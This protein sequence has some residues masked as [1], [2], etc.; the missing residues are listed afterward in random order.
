[1]IEQR[2]TGQRQQYQDQHF[3]QG[4]T[5]D[6]VIFHVT[7]KVHNRKQKGGRIN[8]FDPATGQY[9]A[10]SVS[11]HAEGF[12]DNNIEPGIAPV[13]LALLSRGY[14]TY[15]SCAGHCLSDRRF[16]GIAFPNPIVKMR[17][18]AQ[19]KHWEKEGVVFKELSS[20]IN[21]RSEV[22][23]TGMTSS[24]YGES[25]EQYVSTEEETKVFNIQFHARSSGYSFVEMIILEGSD[26]CSWTSEPVRAV[27]L[28]FRK[29]LHW[30]RITA[31]V[32]RDCSRLVL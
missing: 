10:N 3:L 9:S 22:S 21:Q 18:M 16:V 15:S 32:A 26:T 6:E 30:D 24:Y 2:V 28:W 29:W 7:H 5:E 11:P 14:Y 23:A 19:M 13:V 17:F 4:M 25:G 20:V 27:K 1:M 8:R 31:E 12:A